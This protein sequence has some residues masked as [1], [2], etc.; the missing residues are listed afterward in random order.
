MIDR[1]PCGSGTSAV[2]ANMWAKGEIKK[3][4]LFRHYGILGTFFTGEIVEETEFLPKRATN[5]HPDTSKPIKAVIPTVAG[6]GWITGYNK[7]VIDPTDPFPV[8]YRVKDIW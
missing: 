7:I 5:F 6:R 4:E 1:S 3:N 2:L 8:G